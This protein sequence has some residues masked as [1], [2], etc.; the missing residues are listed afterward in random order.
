MKIGNIKTQRHKGFAILL[1]ISLYTFTISFILE[2]Q[3]FV[4]TSQ[5]N[6]TGKYPES[7]LSIST[8][9]AWCW[10]SD[11]RAVHYENRH[12]RTYI[13]WID[14]YGDVFISSYDHRTG[15]IEKTVLYDS[16]QVDDHVNPS[17]L[18]DSEGFLY[19]F[20][21]KHGGPNPL[22]FV[23][24]LKPEDIS[25]WTT[26]KRL[27]LNDKEFYTGMGDTYTYT[28]P[29]MLSGKMTGFISSGGVLTISQIILFPMIEV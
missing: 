29:V 25:G 1:L 2:A 24:S 6:I 27:E 18:I 28:N 21:N 12:N 8:D 20:F 9:G 3:Y 15:I 19:I 13:G 11:P 26:V 4:R 16:L 10:F 22:Y 7:Y 5:V 17:I 23:K 14:S